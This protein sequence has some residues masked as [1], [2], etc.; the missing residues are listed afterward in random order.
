MST[1]ELTRPVQLASGAIF[2]TVEVKPVLA[3][4]LARIGDDIRTVARHFLA[5]A[6]AE[7]SGAEPAIAGNAEYGA[8]LTVVREMTSLGADA[9][10]LDGA[11]LD[12][13]V[14]AVLFQDDATPGE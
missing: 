2:K 5:A 14:A 1:Y 13:L 3:G 4:D 7:K 8:M 9:E 12:G 10:R 6:A 11:D